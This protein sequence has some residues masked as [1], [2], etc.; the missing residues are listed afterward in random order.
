M[1]SGRYSSFASELFV[2]KSKLFV[3][4]IS[5]LVIIINCWNSLIKVSKNGKNNDVL[6]FP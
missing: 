1:K 2:A 4:Y 6:F 5:V 3:A